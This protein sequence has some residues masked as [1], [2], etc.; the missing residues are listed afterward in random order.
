MKKL[1]WYIIAIVMAGFFVTDCAAQQVPGFINRAAASVA[2][3]AVLDPNGNGYTSIS[4]AGFQPPSDNAT[5]EIPFNGV[6]TYAT[7]PGG[8]INT[9]PTGGFSDIVQDANNIGFYQ[10]LSPAN[11]FLFRFRLGSIVAGAKGYSVLLDT[12]G[13]FGASGANADPNYLPSTS[14]TTGNP[15]FEIEIVLETNSRIAIY[16]VDGN[17]N[18]ILVTAYTNWQDIS[19]ISLAMSN[20]GG[21]PDFFYDFYV[22]FSALQAAPFNL[23][24]STPIRICA[25]TVSNP[26]PAMGGIKSD[27]YGVDGNN[28][29]NSN[30]EYG[31]FVEGQPPTLP[32]GITT[33]RCTKAPVVTGNYGAG[34]NTITGSWTK[35]TLIGSANT[36]TI[37]VYKNGVLIGTILSITTGSTWSLAGITLING[38]IITAKAQAGGESLCQVSNSAFVTTC[39]QAN[40]SSSTS[41]SFGVCVN[42]RRGMA[43]TKLTNVVVKIY[44]YA[45]GVPTLFATDGTPSSPSG[46]NLTYGSP[47]LITNT[48][49]EYNGS[50]NSGSA[51]P[52]SGGPNDIPNG[53]YYIT[54]T[55]PTKCESAPIWGSCVNLTATALPII[56]QAVLYNG[57]T[58]ISGTA[59]AG[60][61][62]GLHVNGFFRASTTATGGNYTFANV[63]LNVG[64]VVGIMA[65]GTGLCVSPFVNRTVTCFTS[66]P[67]INVDANNQVEAGLPITGTSSNPVGSVIRVYNVAGTVLVSSTSVLSNGTWSTAPYNAVAGIS[68]FANAQNG[69][70]SVSANSINVSAAGNTANA[71]CGTIN[72]PVAA[73]ATSVSGTLSSAVAGTVVKLYQDGF[74]IGSVTTSTTSWNITGI[75]A[76]TIYANGTLTIGVQE[77]GTRETFCTASVKIDCSPSPVSP[78][79]SPMNTTIQ[80]NQ[81]ITYTISNAI[82]GNFYAVADVITGASLSTGIWATA[83]GNLQITT[84]PISSPGAYTVVINATSLNGLNVCVATPTTAVANVTG[85]LSSNTFSFDASWVNDEARLQ[86]KPENEKSIESFN[87]EKS[88]DSKEFKVIGKTNTNTILNNSS[89]SFIDNTLKEINNFYRIKIIEKNGSAS[90]SKILLLKNANNAEIK[91][92]PN[93]FAEKININYIALKIEDVAIKVTDLSGRIVMQENLKMQKGNNQFNL[94]MEMSLPSGI[95][96]LQYQEK[97]TGKFTVMKIIKK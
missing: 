95:Y 1:L 90:Y 64:D 54:A 12:D 7:E 91:I 4:T 20:F 24:T 59:V 14:N 84:N 25:T 42:N 46:I 75:V 37:S 55:E 79:Y 48:T 94:P 56:T 40:T 85:V 72:S 35:S 9:G 23:T 67:S 36:A 6:L 39:T 66:T 31:D 10:Y 70:C 43:G 11:N 52:C 51:D 77:A 22:P 29:T 38:D 41:V 89:Y 80:A 50:N 65:Q 13:K 32:G 17:T 93:P 34:V 47:S 33:V 81:S 45:A 78:M 15:G 69:T 18:P 62:V 97:S 3:K 57:N 96:F 76:A 83:N 82:A 68:Y 61:F 73:G 28:Y 74:L 87:I 19:Q 21:T 2:G 86:W 53:S 63:V 71:R 26:G 60:A 92:W 8:D 88:F 58:I 16:N 44:T 49:W 5:S 30:D 27:I